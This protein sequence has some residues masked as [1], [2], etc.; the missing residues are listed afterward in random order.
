MKQ[1]KL[2]EICYDNVKVVARKDDKHDNEVSVQKSGKVVATMNA[3]DW[4]KAKKT[5]D[6]LLAIFVG[7][8]E[9]MLR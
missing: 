9:S 7:D 5:A 4:H 3:D 1:S 6:I 2:Y 8:L